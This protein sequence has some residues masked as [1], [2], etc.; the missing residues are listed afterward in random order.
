VPTGGADWY[1]ESER[2]WAAVFLDT[3]AE[4][5][6]AAAQ[7][8]QDPA[9]TVGRGHMSATGGG[10]APPKKMSIWQQNLD[11]GL[12]NQH[13]L[14]NSLLAGTHHF[15]ALQE[16][17]IGPG[18]WTRADG[19]WRVLYP[20]MHEEE[21]V[22]TRVVTLVNVS[23]P[24]DSW[25]QM[26]FDSPD[27]VA[28]EFRD[29]FRTLRMVN[30]YN[31]GDHDETL[32]ALRDFMRDAQRNRP[33]MGPVHYLWLGD[34]NRHSA[35]WDEI[36]NSHL[37]T[38]D[39]ARAVTPLLQLLGHYNMKMP[40]P[41]GVPT[42]CAKRTGNLTRPDNVFCSE[43]FLDFFVSC[44]A[45][46]SRTPGTTDHFP[47]ISEVDLIPPVRVKEERWDW[48]ATEWE[49]MAKMLEGELALLGDPAGY[50][51]LNEVLDALDKLDEAIWC[52]VAE[53]VLKVKICN[54]SK[55]WWT[56]ELSK[57]RKERERLS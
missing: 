37:F 45:Y 23:L 25:S 20:T 9:A 56:P 49:E 11:R 26:R 36:R 27:A 16:P 40:L 57:F 52:C 47:I 32:R 43:E 54:R 39:A 53:K 50:A 4:R 12:E 28:L 14:I 3:A 35:L 1:E 44:D 41:Q 17:Y 38:A 42:L 7:Q 19:Q 33:P 29:D 10:D 6:K 18:V 34:F 15:A 51:D 30:I 2:A 5:L 46:P 55:R 8:Q 31:D 21:G 13:D 22:R 48:K 24:T